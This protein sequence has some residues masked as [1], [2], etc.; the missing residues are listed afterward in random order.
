MIRPHVL[1]SIQ[2]EAIMVLCDCAP[3]TRTNVECVT[4]PWFL[5]RNGGQNGWLQSFMCQVWEGRQLRKGR[6]ERRRFR[7]LT[8]AVNVSITKIG[9]VK[10]AKCLYFCKLSLS[11][12]SKPEFEWLHSR[13]IKNCTTLWT[14][15][16]SF[17]RNPLS[18]NK[19]SR[20][21]VLWHAPVQYCWALFWEEKPLFC[22][23]YFLQFFFFGGGGGESI[24]GGNFQRVLQRKHGLCLI[25]ADWKLKFICGEKRMCSLPTLMSLS[26]MMRNFKGKQKSL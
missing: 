25:T 7:N 12:V 6:G 14:Y 15:L 24:A 1:L 4:T 16:T 21:I 13:Y 19:Q 23:K 18:S 10:V 2:T 20:V 5:S 26:S 11:R 22:I 9:F 17:L 8:Q 3:W